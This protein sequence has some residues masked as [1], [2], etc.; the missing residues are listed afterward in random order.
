MRLSVLVRQSRFARDRSPEN[1]AV[2]CQKRGSQ[3]KGYR[4]SFW[5]KTLRERTF[6]PPA[7][8]GCSEPNLTNAA[9]S[10]NDRF[11]DVANEL[12]RKVERNGA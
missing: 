8:N 9:P 4:L 7:A 3:Q 1:I 5:F 6:V 2:G 11:W 10:I 12:P